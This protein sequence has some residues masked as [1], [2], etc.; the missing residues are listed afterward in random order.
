[1]TVGEGSEAARF[2]AEAYLAGLEPIGW[3]FGL[4]RIEALLE[5]LGRPQD[6]YETIHVVGTNGKTSVTEIAAALLEAHGVA[7]GAYLSPHRRLW[8]ER[9]R[10][11]GEPLSDDAFAVSVA[12]TA[13]A[14]S[15]V[16]ARLPDRESVTQFEASTAAAFVALADAGVSCGVIEAGLGGRL[17]ATNVM[18]SRATVLTSIGL[19]HTQWL[20]ETEI[21][22]AAEKLAVLQPGTTLIT[23]RLAPD[24]AALAART[25][26]ERDARLVLAPEPPAEA[27]LSSP[28]PYLRRDFAV[29]IEAARVV[30]GDELDAAVVAAVAGEIEF[31]DRLQMIGGDPPL[32]LD[33]AHNPEGAAALAE[34]LEV[35]A[36]DRPVAACLAVLADK[37]AGAIVEKLAPALGAVVCSELPPGSLSGSGRP[38]ASWHPA[39]ELAKLCRAAGIGSVEVIE[40]PEL[41]IA[42]ALEI[43]RREGGVALAAG[44][45]YLLHRA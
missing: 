9:V 20:G 11:G 41:A 23:G 10:V 17:D 7:T 37:D 35:V 30:L 36:G 26:A 29:A 43:A 44:S 8:S 24:V 42:R 1:M 34:A 16:E 25:A 5:E 28:A 15:V 39:G 22:I 12:R 38:G 18:R 6:A 31:P 4:E 45:H 27:R 2:D 19:D 14:I 32:Y 3:R 21:E 40:D 13:E 33:A